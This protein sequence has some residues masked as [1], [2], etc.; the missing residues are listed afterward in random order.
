M[1]V[2]HV[3]TSIIKAS[4]TRFNMPNI[5][6]RRMAYQS[7][8]AHLHIFGVCASSIRWQYSRDTLSEIDT[9]KFA[10]SLQ[11]VARPSSGFGARGGQD[12]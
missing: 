2:R 8:Q 6:Y 11:K 3:Y 4:D 10:Q 5:S 1:Q 9:L 7:P 12:E